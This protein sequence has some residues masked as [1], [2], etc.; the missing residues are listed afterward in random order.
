MTVTWQQT[1]NPLTPAVIFRNGVSSPVWIQKHWQEGTY[2]QY[3]RNN[4]CG[5]CCC[6]MAA[7][8]SGVSIDPYEAYLLCHTLW[9]AP[10]GT[11]DHY[12]TAAGIRAVLEHLQIPAREFGV[13]K[14]GGKA[15]AAHIME[16]LRQDKMVILT[17]EPSDRLPNNPFSTGL[18][19]ILLAGFHPDGSVFVANSSLKAAG[20]AVQKTDEATIAAAISEN[21]SPAG[22]TWGDCTR[23]PDGM[24][25]L[26]V[27]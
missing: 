10:T 6:A 17:S 12:Q 26:T 16:A 13:E 9:G 15:A 8:L 24:G 2:A 22:M 7:T 27:G 14:N 21:C 23:L 5:H 3:I 20:L 1:Q 25:Y 18:H 19:W 11:Q 4:G